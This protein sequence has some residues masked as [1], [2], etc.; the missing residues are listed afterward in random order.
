MWK[1][2]RHGNFTM[3]HVGD[4]AQR[5]QHGPKMEAEALEK[6]K[7]QIGFT[8]SEADQPTIH[9]GLSQRVKAVTFS[10]SDKILLKQKQY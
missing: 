7:W 2:D 6:T 10:K 5:Q 9:F 8:T 1:A 3:F 4:E